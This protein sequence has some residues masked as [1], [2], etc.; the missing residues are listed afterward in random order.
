[1]LASELRA[2]FF[3]EPIVYGACLPVGRRKRRKLLGEIIPRE[4]WWIA[5]P[6]DKLIK[7]NRNANF[8]DHG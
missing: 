2:G 6:R 4:R 7:E 5:R 1:M 8:Q 3:I